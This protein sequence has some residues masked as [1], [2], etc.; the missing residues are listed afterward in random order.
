[1]SVNP[2]PSAWRVNTR[3]FN[4][5]VGFHQLFD[6]RS[7]ATPDAIALVDAQ[8]R[9]SYRQLAHKSNQLAAY[10]AGQGVS[11]GSRVALFMNRSLDLVVA[12]LAIARVG[13]TYIPLDPAYP[14]QRLRYM[15]EDSDSRWVLTQAEVEPTLATLLGEHCASLALDRQWPLVAACQSPLPAPVSAPDSLAYIIYTSG[16]TGQPKGVMISHRALSNFLLSM[17]EEPGMSAADTLLAVTTHC[18]DISGLELLLPLIVG[19]R[20]HI[21]PTET[22]A[23]ASQLMKL[24]AE[25]RPSLMQATPATW[26]MLLRAGWQPPAQLRILCGGEPLP[27]TLKGAFEQAG[28]A[29]WNMFGPTETTIWSTLQKLQPGQVVSIGRPIA[30]TRLYLLR[31]DGSHCA[32]GEPGELC[33]AGVGLAE[34]YLNRPELTAEKFIE[35]PF[36]TSGKLYRTGDLACWQADGLLQHLGR[37]DNQVKI[38]G[39]RVE[40]GDVE[41][42][43]DNHPEVLHG[44]VVARQQADSAQLVGYFVPRDQAPDAAL[45][46]RLKSWLGER[47][48]GFMVPSFLLAIERIPL[49][50]NGKVDR[51]ALVQRPISVAAGASTAARSEVELYIIEQWQALLGVEDIQPDSLFAEVGGNS[52]AA[53]AFLARLNQRFDTQLVLADLASHASPAAIAQRLLHGPQAAPAAVAP[54]P[55]GDDRRAQRDDDSREDI[56]IVGMA[57]SFAQAG[58]AQAFWDNVL[59]GRNCMTSAARMR[60]QLV[61]ADAPLWA[62]FIADAF[63]FDPVFFQLAPKEAQLIDPQQRLM[64]TYT[65]RALEDAGISAQAFR[66]RRTGVFI[67]ASQNDYGVA[68]AQAEENKGYLATGQLASM[69]ANRLSHTLDLSGPSECIETTC[70]SSLVALHRA[71]RAIRHHECEQAVVGGVN[72]LLSS[73]YFHSYDAMGLLSPDRSTRSFQAG[74]N[75]YVRSEGAAVVILKPLARAL[76]DNDRIAAVIKGSSVNHGGR[77]SSLTAPNQEGMRNA[78]LDALADA[79][80]AAQSL[81]YIETHATGSLLGDRVEVNALEAVFAEHNPGAATTADCTLGSLKPCIGHSEVASGMAALIKVVFAL[82]QGIKPGVPGVSDEDVARLWSSSVF[83]IS[84]RNQPWAAGATPRR[85]AIN[86]YGFGVNAHV[87]VEQYCPPDDTRGEDHDAQLLV[88]SART[89]TQLASVLENQLAHLHGHPQ[90]RLRDLAYTLQ[91]GREG[92]KVRLAFVASSI[93][94]AREQLARA[95]EGLAEGADAWPAGIFYSGR[96]LVADGE[97]ATLAAQWVAGALPAWHSLHPPGS[98]KKLAL[99]Q[100]PFQFKRYNALAPDEPEPAARRICVIGAGPGGLVMAKSLLEEGHQPVV[101]EAQD[102]LGG[103]WNLKRDKEVGTYS[104][105]RFQNSRDTSFF[106]DFYPEDVSDTFPNV[107]DVRRY[108]Q[109]YASHFDLER[110]IHCQSRVVS[111]KAEGTGW[112]VEIESAGIRRQETFDGVALCHGR[113]QIPRHARIPGLESFTGQV[114]HSGQYFDNAPLAGKRVL[115]IGNGVSGMDIAGEASKVAAKVYWSLRSR[116][117]ILPRMVG[118]LPNDFVSPANLLMPAGLRAQRNI[119]RLRQA[120]PAFSEALQRSG[121][122]PTLNEFRQH[123]FIHINDEVVDLVN[124]GKIETIFGQV[125]KFVGNRC[126]HLGHEQ[127]LDDIDVVVLCT[128]YRTGALYDYVQGLEPVRDLAMGLF[129]RDDPLLFNQY[130]LQEI[131]VIGTF[132]YLEMT[133]R[134]YAQVVSGKYRL[135]QQELRQT[136]DTDKIIMGPLASVVIGMKLGLVPDPVRE[137]KAFWSL[138]NTPGFPAQYRLRGPHA[139]AGAA[140]IVAA[141]RQRAFIQDE[142]GDEQISIVKARLLA[143]LGSEAVARLAAEGQITAEE[144]QTALARLDDPLLL[145]WD[146]Q[147]LTPLSD[148]AIAIDQATESL[149]RAI[150]EH[151]RLYLGLLR[152]IQRKEINADN[153]LSEL[154][155]ISRAS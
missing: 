41:A 9:L 20:C 122:Q 135:S 62:G 104:T 144:R 91:V 130:G 21:C 79:R 92:L 110:H 96:H 128:G 82:Q 15:L 155:K 109:A 123:P 106:S 61:R 16:S 74:A 66:Q 55:V 52:I 58:C 39:Y 89:P 50:P 93:A 5:E 90:L 2:V 70:S 99:P 77:S 11:A 33:I 78:M 120:M 80:V 134:W 117:F 4:N 112:Q 88:F 13:A 60:P 69:V 115:V 40:M 116:K 153:F 32:I 68:A 83:R 23:D 111:V 101:Y 141:S 107:Q 97:L 136:A 47:L 46:G 118:F 22:A 57:C 73:E 64:L 86:S 140:A 84:A 12:M 121:L 137:L 125:E 105:T 126:F 25:V 146:S 119:D 28:N 56:A 53:N 152:K 142:T 48:P 131:G 18:F 65:W 151:D 14:E 19:G 145:D 129:Y 75:G 36:E 24:I 34:G 43:L 139:S 8:H 49:T 154:K 124:A 76:A 81:G 27:E 1:M 51:K 26:M 94:E 95:L 7:Q 132:P 143:G 31:E 108:L 133:S 38:R 114:L 100:Y 6:T 59:V 103:V 113:Y 102:T 127:V 54:E 138:L 10:L 72:L 45:A 35:N 149:D 30:N 42:Q 98:A 63:D 29:T 67:A 85:A 3:D 17:A 44:V 147:F 37:I 87:I 150:A 148:R 71:I